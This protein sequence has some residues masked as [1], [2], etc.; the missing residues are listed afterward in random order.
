MLV[1]R[2]ARRGR[3]KQAFFHLVVAEKA[4]AVQKKIIEKLGFLNPHSEGGKGEFVF[5]AKK[6][7]EYIANGA[8]LS[9]RAARELSKAGVKEAG[10]F[11]K[12]RPTKPKKEVVKKPEP[13]KEEVSVPESEDSVKDEPSTESVETPSDGNTEKNDSPTEE[14]PKGE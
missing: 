6:V 8:Q 4:K 11:V 1:I 2:F 3:N 12:A 5:D 10:K 13:V 7:N 9:Q 14:L